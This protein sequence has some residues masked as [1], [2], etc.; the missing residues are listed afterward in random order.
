VAVSGSA[1]TPPRTLPDTNDAVLHSQFSPP[2]EPSVI[3]EDKA[4]ITLA[5]KFSAGRMVLLLGEGHLPNT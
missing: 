5:I 2:G 4:S 3:A 1:L